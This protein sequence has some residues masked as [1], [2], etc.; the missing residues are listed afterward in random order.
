MLTLLKF[1]AQVCCVTDLGRLLQQPKN[2]LV[3]EFRIM[4]LFMSNSF[5]VHQAESIA[6]LSDFKKV[7]TKTFKCW[8]V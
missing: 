4:G 2:R 7:W 3:S 5:E 6:D 1:L 8:K